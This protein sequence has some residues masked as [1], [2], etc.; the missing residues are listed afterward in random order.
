MTSAERHPIKMKSLSPG[1]LQNGPFEMYS[2]MSRVDPPEIAP[3]VGH[4][5]YGERTQG[6]SPPMPK[7]PRPRNMGVGVAGG[8][9]VAA[10]AAVAAAASAVAAGEYHHRAH[11]RESPKT[12]RERSPPGGLEE[13]ILDSA[14]RAVV[15]AHEL[16][17]Q[18]RMHSSESRPSLSPDR[19]LGSGEGGRGARTSPR[20][21]VPMLHPRNG[22][23][24]EQAIKDDRKERRERKERRRLSSAEKEQE[25]L[26]EGVRI[27]EALVSLSLSPPQPLHTRSSRSP[28][29]VSENS[30]V[31][32]TS[33]RRSTPGAPSV[34]LGWG[35]NVSRRGLSMSPRAFAVDFDA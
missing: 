1:Q 29:T 33:V 11:V 14:E 30:V 25:R 16:R 23:V 17:V 21:A 9:D 6:A 4:I 8:G 18:T 2:G 26:R 35:E 20:R 13:H 27:R 24:G 3:C 7:T 31:R 28:P 15:V 10:A 5:Y 34:A 19:E 22:Q 12:R 32:A